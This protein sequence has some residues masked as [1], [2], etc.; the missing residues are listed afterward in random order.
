MECEIVAL[1]YITLVISA[2][3]LEF[4]YMVDRLKLIDEH[5]NIPTI[6]LHHPLPN[7]SST[8]LDIFS[9]YIRKERRTPKRI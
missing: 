1:M 7:S 5:G 9:M 4:G 3:N 8:N 2:K 6:F